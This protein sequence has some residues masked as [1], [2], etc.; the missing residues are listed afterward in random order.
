MLE[1]IPGLLSPVAI[2]CRVKG[3]DR[4]VWVVSP[5]LWRGMIG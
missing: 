5:E 2:V 1:L 4:A 3:G